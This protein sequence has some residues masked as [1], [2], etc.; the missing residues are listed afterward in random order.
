LPIL[1]AKTW[2]LVSQARVLCA[3][4]GPTVDTLLWLDRC[5]RMTKRFVESVARLAQVPPMK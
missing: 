2:L 5:A 1:D 3:T 4:R